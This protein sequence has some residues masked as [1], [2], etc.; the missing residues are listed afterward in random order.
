MG[1]G[2]A[3]VSTVRTRLDGGF[4]FAVPEG[5]Q[6]LQAIVSPPGGALKAYEVT[7]AKE[8]KILLQVEPLGGELVIDLG[9]E[10]AEEAFGGR[11]L[12][13][14]QGGIGLPFGTMV[15]WAEG[16]GVR[17]FEH[18]RVRIPQLAPGSYTVCLGTPAV[19]DPSEIE[20]WKARSACASGYLSAG[21]T[22][23]L[24]LK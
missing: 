17:F 14:L 9:K 1:S 16:H 4:E 7:L 12:A 21:S 8:A 5:T 3:L 22:L 19:L 11:I 6:R 24:R 10:E 13:V 20:E 18:G 23:N 2:N 15:H